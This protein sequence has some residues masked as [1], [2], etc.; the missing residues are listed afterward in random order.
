MAGVGN[1]RNR[2]MMM[3]GDD[4]DWQ[5]GCVRRAEEVSQEVEHAARTHV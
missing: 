3:M 1:H 2:S 5:R 4:D